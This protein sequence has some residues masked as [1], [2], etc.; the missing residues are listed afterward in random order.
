M[1]LCQPKAG[2][3]QRLVASVQAAHTSKAAMSSTPTMRQIHVKV[4][5]QLESSVS[6]FDQE[7]ACIATCLTLKLTDRQ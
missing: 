2:V 6:L 1:H 3:Q 7:S 4:T 5:K